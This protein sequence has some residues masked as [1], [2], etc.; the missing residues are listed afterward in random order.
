MMGATSAADHATPQPRSLYALL[1][2]MAVSL[3]G[4]NLTLVAVPWFV[5]ETTN[6]PA[7]T[8]V[9][10]FA[11]TLPWIFSAIFG[12][13]LV[14]RFGYRRTSMVS[15]FMCGFTVA[16]IPMLF[17]FDSLQFWVLLTV[18]F[19][20]GV[21][22]AGGETA[23]LSLLPDAAEAAGVD[24]ERA[25]GW[26]EAINR[27]MKVVGAPVAAFL[28]LTIGTQNVLWVDAATYLI[29]AV[30]V[31]AL[32]T[33]RTLAA[34]DEGYVEEMRKGLRF[35]TGD[36][37][38]V[39][40]IVISIIS[41]AFE[42]PLSLVVLPSYA[43][44]LFNTPTILGL[45]IGAMGLGAAIGALSYERLARRFSRRTLLLTLFGLTASRYLVLLLPVPIPVIV[46]IFLLLS[47]A[48]GPLNPLFSTVFYARI[49]VHLRGRVFGAIIAVASA[50]IPVAVLGFGALIETFGVRP[51][52]AIAGTL[53]VA[54]S[55]GLVFNRTVRALDNPR[56]GVRADRS[57][58]GWAILRDPSG[59]NEPVRVFVRNAG[60]EWN[61]QELV[62]ESVVYTWPTSKDDV[63][64][65]WSAQLG[66]CAA[67]VESVQIPNRAA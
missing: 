32:V 26:F 29:S 42:T 24:I 64:W 3:I 30:L 18:V 16:A 45:L 38:I 53:Y 25:N 6:S 13:P 14:D 46:G 59:A 10:A 1:A 50:A 31:G 35:A 2:A 66:W 9:I 39:L 34:P 41:N 57:H 15:D 55:I 47:L 20:R 56:L 61:E 27:G 8:G 23:R 12:G 62:A 49:P 19:V 52:I 58:L 36:R 51:T 44:E 48:D 4:N 54:I 60:D 22:D 21:L 40:L 37:I 63:R 33:T 43:H 5:L 11:V 65:V 67:C 7:K 17:L 28:V